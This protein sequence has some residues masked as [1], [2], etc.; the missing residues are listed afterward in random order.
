[1]EWVVL[2]VFFLSCPVVILSGSKKKKIHKQKKNTSCEINGLT[3]GHHQR[4]FKP[5]APPKAGEV[6]YL[7]HGAVIVVDQ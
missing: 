5:R 2:I 7:S 6:A 1:M 3:V 4:S